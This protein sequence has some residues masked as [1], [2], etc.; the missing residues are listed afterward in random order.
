MR[1]DGLHRT[2]I[3]RQ[4]RTSS[5]GTVTAATLSNR[6][7][8]R[9]FWV[10]VASVGALVAVLIVLANM[11]ISWL[12]GEALKAGLST[13]PT[14][15][16]IEIGGERLL[17]PANMI[18]FSD[19]RHAGPQE[20]L[21][22]IIHWPSLRGYS[23]ANTKSF[24]DVSSTAP[25]VF[26]SLVRRG[27]AV[28]STTRLIGLYTRFFDGTGGSGPAGLLVRNLQPGSGYESEEIFFEP[29]STA[30]F[31]ARC[32]KGSDRIVPVTCLRDIHVGD[33]LSVAYRFRKPLIAHWKKLDPAIYMLIDRMRV[34]N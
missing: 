14:P 9:Q 28:D 20:R 18:R 19:Q 8:S 27:T 30:P 15:L 10:P 32:T 4:F 13:D 26:L 17:V 1:A 11:A 23:V 34:K 21:D 25:L 12:S 7:T 33:H 2:A 29:G 31:S 3:G 16:E 5:G 6:L 22:L 24:D